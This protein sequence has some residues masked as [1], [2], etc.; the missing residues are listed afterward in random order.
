MLISYPNKIN[1]NIFNLENSSFLFFN[2]V[3]IKATVLKNL[4]AQR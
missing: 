2:L 3:N 1:L 4:S